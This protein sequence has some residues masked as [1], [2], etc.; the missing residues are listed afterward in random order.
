MSHQLQEQHHEAG[1]QYPQA[2]Y[3]PQASGNTQSHD[4][5]EQPQQ[6]HHGG[7]NYNPDQSKGMGYVPPPPQVHHQHH[8][9][10]KWEYGLCG[11]FSK[12][13]VCK[14][15]TLPGR[16]EEG[17]REGCPDPRYILYEK[18]KKSRLANFI[19]KAAPVGGVLVFSLEGLG[20]VCIIPRWTGILAATE[21]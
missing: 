8:G 6:L 13:G 10:Q 5:P 15:T 20:I 7:Y 19:L 9:P 14:Y 4:Y 3:S 18:K 16:R 12:C 1:H 11:C 2:A 17:E 21:E